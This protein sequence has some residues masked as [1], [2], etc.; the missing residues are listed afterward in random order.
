MKMKNLLC[1]TACL[2]LFLGSTKSPATELVYTPLNP[3]FGGNPYN[4]SW[5]L[6]SAQ[7][8]DKTGDSGSSYSYQQSTAL[9]DFTDSINRQI[10]SR[11]SSKLVTQAFGEETLEPGHYEIGEYVIDVSPLDTGIRVNIMDPLTGQDTTIELPYYG[12]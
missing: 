11:L 9:E 4:S 1:F 10:L 2:V 7:A 6:S 12:Q 5:M 3:S 8:Q